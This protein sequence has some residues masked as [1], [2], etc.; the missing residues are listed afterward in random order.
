MTKQ[1]KAM[2]D[3]LASNYSNVTEACKLVGVGRTTHYEWMNGI[4]QYKKACDEVK[5]SL[6]D[7]AESILHSKFEKDTTALIFFLKCKGGY[8]ETHE[9]A[10]SGSVDIEIL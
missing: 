9:V 6:V 1:Q 2:V 10:H 4:E 7:R 8:K 3:A 5:T